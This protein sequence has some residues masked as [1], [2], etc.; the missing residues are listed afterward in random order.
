[1]ESDIKQMR[2]FEG[3]EAN[4]CTAR[5]ELNLRDDETTYWGVLCRTCS[6]PIAFDI[7]PHPSFG[8]GSSNVKA[9]AIRCGRGHNHIYFPRDFRILSSALP[10]CGVVMLENR[11]AY[12]AI[13]SSYQ[14]SN[15]D[16]RSPSEKTEALR[17]EIEIF[18]ESNDLP[19]DEWNIVWK[20][21]LSHERIMVKLNELRSQK[22]S[23]H[24]PHRASP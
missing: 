21:N 22:Q 15:S 19:P 5:I 9:G 23:Q 10:I 18:G 8:P 16:N 4:S 17:R 24:K 6:E 12:K 3:V 1:M 11:E 14:N 20:S 7:N 13:N 2:E